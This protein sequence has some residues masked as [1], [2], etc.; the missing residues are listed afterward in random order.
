VDPALRA[1]LKPKQLLQVFVDGRIAFENYV[2]GLPEKIAIG[3]P[4]IQ[5]ERKVRV[6]VSII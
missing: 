3:P 5:P 4:F 2:D 1:Q 6:Q